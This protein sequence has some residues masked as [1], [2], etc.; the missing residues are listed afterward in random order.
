MPALLGHGWR[1]GGEAVKICRRCH[2]RPARSGQAWCRE[3]HSRYMRTWRKKTYSKGQLRARIDLLERA[4][5]TTLA[6]LGPGTPAWTWGMKVLQ[7]EVDQDVPQD[8]SQ[9]MVE[10]HPHSHNPPAELPQSSHN[11]ITMMG[12][13]LIA[14][15]DY[16]AHRPPAAVT[17]P[18]T[19]CCVNPACDHPSWEHPV[20]LN[21][22]SLGPIT[23]PCQHP[24]C[25]CREYQR[26]QD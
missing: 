13:P 11:P 23:E 14:D 16:P 10:N 6:Q 24:R 25:S 1:A 15:P 12:A 26:P 20:Q 5:D 17:D 4:L 8:T 2:K 18:V 19:P 21:P 3:C 9:K 22:H 7:A